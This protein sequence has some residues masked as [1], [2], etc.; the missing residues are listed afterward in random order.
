MKRKDGF[1]YFKLSYS[2]QLWNS[3]ATT[4]FATFKELANFLAYFGALNIQF[5][6]LLVI[7]TFDLIFVHP[8]NWVFRIVS[9]VLKA[10]ILTTNYHISFLKLPHHWLIRNGTIIFLQ[11]TYF[12][13]LCLSVEMTIFIRVSMVITFWKSTYLT[14]QTKNVFDTWIKKIQKWTWFF[15]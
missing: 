9:Y 15:S 14:F 8:T 4:S 3:W 10:V 6:I 5:A 2:V 12:I 13:F 7:E 11:Y 1:F